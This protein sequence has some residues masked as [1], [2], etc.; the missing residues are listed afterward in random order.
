M[1]TS[2]TD[3]LSEINVKMSNFQAEYGQSGGAIINL[4]TKSGTKQ[5]HGDI[6]SYLR[7]E[8]LNANDY[9]NNVNHVVKPR[10]RYVIGG[11]SIGGPVYIPGRFNTAKNKIFFFFNDQY[12]RQNIP[13]SLIENTVPT[14][15]ERAGNFSQS[16]TV[17][18]SL[19]PINMPAPR[20]PSPGISFLRA[21]SV[22]MDRTC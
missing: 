3:S 19:I 9:F 1:A 21:R 15:L 11:G 4:T 16:L 17:G 2:A 12:Y 14:A 22:P 8:D 6:Y 13:G 5:F 18:G 10:Y 20:R 7:N